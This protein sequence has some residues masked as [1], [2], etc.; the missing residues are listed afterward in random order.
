VRYPTYCFTGTPQAP[1]TTN[2]QAAINNITGQGKDV[3]LLGLYIQN[4][5]TAAYAGTN[6]E[7]RLCRSSGAV[8]G[9]AS[10]LVKHDTSDT[11]IGSGVVAVID[12]PTS[13][14]A[15]TIMRLYTLNTADIG[16][17]AGDRNGKPYGDNL[18]AVPDGAKPIVIHAG[19]N[20]SLNFVNADASGLVRIVWI[21][22]VVPAGTVEDYDVNSVQLAAINTTLGSMHTDLENLHTDLGTTIHGDLDTVEAKLADLHTDLGTSLYGLL[23]TVEAKLA[24]LHTDLGTTLHADLGTQ[25]SNK[26]NDLV[27]AFTVTINNRLAD[28]HSDLGSV[29]TD[30]AALSTSSSSSSATLAD[31]VEAINFLQLQ[32]RSFQAMLPN[33]TWVSWDTFGP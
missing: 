29:H 20:L 16:K 12:T 30:L 4:V 17:D 5:K 31:V 11:T 14:A 23:D 22:A 3:V 26:I 33:G 18:A 9:T 27:S 2:S 8:T 15:T 24:D 6:I 1:Q 19:E 13:L 10:G 25:I 21:V 32:E 28:I 7:A